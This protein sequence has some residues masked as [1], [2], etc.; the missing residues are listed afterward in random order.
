MSSAIYVDD[1]A[2]P[3]GSCFCNDFCQHMRLIKVNNDSS[4]II[5]L[6]PASNL[7]RII[8]V[9]N[10]MYIALIF[11]LQLLVG[12]DQ[13]ETSKIAKLRMLLI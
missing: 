5:Q 2:A 13:A 3:N 9:I 4:F 6:M 11:N 8:T 1:V 10:R 12:I 7:V